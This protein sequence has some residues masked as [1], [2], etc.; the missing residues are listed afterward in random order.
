MTPLGLRQAIRQRGVVDTLLT[1]LTG[2]ASQLAVLISGIVAARVLGSRTQAILRRSSFL[3]SLILTYL[4]SLGVP[5][6]LTYFIASDHR[7]A[8]AL[9]AKVTPVALAQIVVVLAVHAGLLIIFFAHS[10]TDINRRRNHARDLGRSARRSSTAWQSFRGFSSSRP[11]TSCDWRR[12][13][14]MR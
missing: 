10:R 1:T 14:A 3:V 8:A 7:R 4:G 5:L 12:R 13:P 11:S 6:A 9:A 2:V